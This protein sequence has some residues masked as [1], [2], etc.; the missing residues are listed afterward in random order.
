MAT[1]IQYYTLKMGTDGSADKGA[2]AKTDHL[3][4]IPKTQLLQ[5]VL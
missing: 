1:D 2:V 4:S 3:S 5:V